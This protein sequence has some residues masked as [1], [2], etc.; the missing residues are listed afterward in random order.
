MS[1]KLSDQQTARTRSVRTAAAEDGWNTQ[2]IISTETTMQCE[3]SV[4][5]LLHRHPRFT[6]EL[7]SY[8]HTSIDW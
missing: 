8:F 2:L 6:D 1:S 7:K 3:A 4:K 5:Q